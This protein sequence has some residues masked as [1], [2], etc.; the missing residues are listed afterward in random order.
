MIRAQQQHQGLTPEKLQ[1]FIVGLSN[2]NQEE[3]RKA[4]LLFIRNEISELKALKTTY[5][6]FGILQ[7]CFAIIPLFW[8]ILWMQ[9]SAMKAALKLHVEQIQNA[10]T[11][12]SQDLGEETAQLELQLKE[13]T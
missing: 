7:G 12:W 1:M 2:M 9:R 3:A 11:V 6:S 4:K 13:L 8:P 10:L 5:K